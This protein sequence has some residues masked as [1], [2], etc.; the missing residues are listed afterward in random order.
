[1]A[2]ITRLI[3]SFARLRVSARTDRPDM[4]LGLWGGRG[5]A[6]RR[7]QRRECSARRGSRRPSLRPART[8]NAPTARLASAPLGAARLRPPA[9]ARTLRTRSP[10]RRRQPAR[11]QDGRGAVRRSADGGG[12]RLCWRRAEGEGLPVKRNIC[13]GCSQ[14]RNT[15][16]LSGFSAA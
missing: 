1:M 12:R 9:G 14:L 15:R 4:L 2:A 16:W 11:A 5:G 6:G 8:H 13:A 7:P 10:L 3:S